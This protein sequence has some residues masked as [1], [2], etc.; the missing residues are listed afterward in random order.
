M[1]PSERFGSWS[2][3]SLCPPT[4]SRVLTDAPYVVLLIWDPLGFLYNSTQQR[5][6]NSGHCTKQSWQ[7]QHICDFQLQLIV[8]MW[9]WCC[10]AELITG[11][12]TTTFSCRFEKAAAPLLRLSL[13]VLFLFGP[14]WSRWCDRFGFSWWLYYAYLQNKHCRPTYT[15]LRNTLSRRHPL[16][17]MYTKENLRLIL[18]NPTRVPVSLWEGGSGSHLCI[19][20][21]SANYDIISESLWTFICYKEIVKS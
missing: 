3:F 20:S 8:N 9:R 10:R 6:F 4:V 18:T 15:W 13:C 7:Y 19:I 12:C 11:D 5:C 14:V 1:A 17:G 21:A 2:V 16:W